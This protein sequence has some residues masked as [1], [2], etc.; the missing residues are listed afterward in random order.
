MIWFGCV[1]WHIKPCGLFNAKS[2]LSLSLYIYIYIYILLY[3]SRL[4]VVDNSLKAPLSIATTLRCRGG[5]Y[6]FPWIAPLY[7][8][9][10]PYNAESEARRQQVPFFWVFGMT[11]PRIEPWS[12]W[13][14]ANTQPTMSISQ[15]IYMIFTWIFCMM[16]LFLNKPKL[17]CLNTV[18]WFKVLLLNMNNPIWYY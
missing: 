6:S 18:K 9:S 15:F 4:T 2:S 8:W 5:H 3:I 7:S 13:T 12:P 1:L 16:T 11:Q 10:V 14:L 17:I